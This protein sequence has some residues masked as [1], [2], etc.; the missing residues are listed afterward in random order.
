MKK[1]DS[2]WPFF[3]SNSYKW[4]LSIAMGI[5]FYLF[6]IAFLPFGISNYDPN[7]QYTFHFLSQIS[8]V[9]IVVAAVSL[10]NEFLLKPILFRRISFQSVLLW[11]GFSLVIISLAVFINYNLWGDWHDFR[12]TS[13]ITFIFQ[14][15]SVLIFPMFGVFFY[16]KQQEYKQVIE[17]LSLNP[18]TSINAEELLT[19]KGSGIN[20][21]I[22]LSVEVFIY[23]QSS[24]NYVE[25]FYRKEAG[26]K[27][28]LIRGTMKQIQ[29]SA[30]KE[31][32]CR[33]HRK[34]LVNLHQVEAVKG[35]QHNMQLIIPS[36]DVLLPVG[37]AYSEDLLLQ[38]KKYKNFG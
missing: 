25:L 38:L 35:A 3:L 20:D 29:E 21:Q 10:F 19:F 33:C 36:A 37:K 9:I 5:F 7:H 4:M 30:D 12:L 28:H 22:S 15:S 6:L 27:K 24:N 8:T 23:A 16:F 34:Y 14:C 32:I 13:A 17:E 2:K 26:I 18:E 11:N 1:I 31:F